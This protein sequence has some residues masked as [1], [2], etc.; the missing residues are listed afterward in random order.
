MAVRRIIPYYESADFEATRVFYAEVLG[1]EEGSFGGGYIS[2]SAPGRRRSFSRR[3]AWSRCCPTWAWT[4]T[5]GKLL[6]RHTLKHYGP[7]TR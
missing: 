6:M 3:Q 1:L 7:D 4:W 5:R 2:A